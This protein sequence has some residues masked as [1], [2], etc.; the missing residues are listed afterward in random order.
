MSYQ[1]PVDIFHRANAAQIPAWQ[2]RLFP[3]PLPRIEGLDL[4]G[5]C[6]PAH[7]AGGDFY[8]FIPLEPGGLALSL[9]DVSGQGVGAGILMSGLQA[10]LR[11]LTRQGGR[12]I[13]AVVRELNRT[14]WQ[15][16]PD[17]FYATL[18]YAYLDPVLGEM[19]YV[20]AGHESA[21]L[22][23]RRTGRVHRLDST[24]T[25]LGL[26]DRV[27]F[28]QRTLPLESGDLLI[29][30]TDG[31]ADAPN[32]DGLEF[33]EQG[34]L[35]VVQRNPHARAIDLAN[36]ILQAVDQHTGRAHAADD[37]TAVVVRF[38]DAAAKAVVEEVMAM[39]AA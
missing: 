26:S 22:I 27:V 23:R 12:E 4:H 39:A 21:L 18:F 24:G 20:S 32:A 6:R 14:V 16:S 17:N 8:D 38:K 2:G 25:V 13:G 3:S 35:E 11:A 37:R 33:G 1:N 29:A 30:T 9:G 15:T 7:D 28:G 36:E 5:E 34:I 31:I 10:L 19:Q